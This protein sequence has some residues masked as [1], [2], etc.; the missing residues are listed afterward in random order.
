M[1]LALFFWRFTWLPPGLHAV[2][3]LLF[4]KN[5]TRANAQP[6]AW[7]LVSNVVALILVC[8]LGFAV[9]RYWFK[10]GRSGGWPPVDATM[11]SSS[12]GKLHF[13]RGVDYV[14]NF[15]VYG[16]RVLGDRYVRFFALCSVDSLARGLE[17]DLPGKSLR[18]RYNPSD[19]NE[20]YLADDHDV[21]FTGQTS[22]QYPGWLAQDPAT[23]LQD[24]IR[25]VEKRN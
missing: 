22:T 14:A 3:W 16:F 5:L 17:D 4:E 13:G 15:H 20:S 18:I 8:T 19:P 11:Q 21:R 24:A 10:L 12:L 1:M 2:T 7:N 9:A 23:D 6:A 25:T